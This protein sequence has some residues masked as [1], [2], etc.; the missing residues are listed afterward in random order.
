MSTG[1]EILQYNIP[2]YLKNIYTRK[3]NHF[4]S[5]FERKE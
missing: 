4:K 2:I 1:T 3:I 5:Y